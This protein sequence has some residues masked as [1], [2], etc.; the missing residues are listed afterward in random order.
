M[1]KFIASGLGALALTS[2]F[3]FV[4]AAPAGA[5]AVVPTIC[6]ALPAQQTAANA[7]LAVA[8]GALGSATTTLNAKNVLMQTAFSS[9]VSAVVDWLQAVDA[10][11][12][13]ADAKTLMDNKLADLAAKIADWSAAK[14]GVFNAQNTVDGANASV[15]ALNQFFSEL[16]GS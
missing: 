4:G 15:Q 10:G 16:C 9:Y 14:V 8:T 2:G 3:A 6:L 7:A 13:I 5:V 11:T 12:G 1:R